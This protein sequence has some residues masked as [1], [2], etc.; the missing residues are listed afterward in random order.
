MAG[1]PVDT[2]ARSRDYTSS[3]SGSKNAGAEG[4]GSGLAKG[5]NK[6]ST[7]NAW[8]LLTRSGPKQSTLFSPCELLIAMELIHQS[9]FRCWEWEENGLW[10][11]RPVT[12]SDPTLEEPGFQREQSTGT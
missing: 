8:K 6:F 10:V 11:H 5:E 4:S 3:G 2:H 9:D 1:D 7:V 12:R